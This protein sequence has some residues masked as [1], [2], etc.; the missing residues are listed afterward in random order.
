[1]GK[2]RP[3]RAGARAGTRFLMSSTKL[4]SLAFSGLQG[5]L[6]TTPHFTDEET[7]AQ[8]PRTVGS[9]STEKHCHLYDLQ[10]PLARMFGWLAVN[11][12]PLKLQ[13]GENYPQVRCRVTEQMDL[14]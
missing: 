5:T 4:F 6:K 10:R 7:K 3:E 11:R 12:V 14:F 2:L 1:M 9:F 13:R 8:I